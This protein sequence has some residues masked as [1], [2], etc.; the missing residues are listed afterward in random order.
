MEYLDLEQKVAHLLQLKPII[1]PNR[2]ARPPFSSWKN[3]MEKRLAARKDSLA[4][5]SV[6][7][8]VIGFRK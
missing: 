8:Q 7:T 6:T 3:W 1:T 2:V 5:F 4:K